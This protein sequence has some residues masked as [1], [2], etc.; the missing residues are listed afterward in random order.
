MATMYFSL[1]A[2]G[3]FIGGFALFVK[4]KPRF[5]DLL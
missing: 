1:F 3:L 2:L 4:A 5:A